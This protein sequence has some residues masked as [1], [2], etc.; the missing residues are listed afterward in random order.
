MDFRL[1]AILI[2]IGWSSLL[3]LWLLFR[4]PAGL[5]RLWCSLLATLLVRLLP[6]LIWPNGAHYEMNVFRQV[7]SATLE[8]QSVYLTTIPHPHL[9]MQLDWFAFALWLENQVGLS[10]AFWIKFPSIL[11]EMAMISLIYSVV[12][13]TGTEADALYSSWSMV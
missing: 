8:H 11:T 1:I 12:R 7:A 4:R 5:P 6:A 3:T 13:R 10:F 2:W 9:P